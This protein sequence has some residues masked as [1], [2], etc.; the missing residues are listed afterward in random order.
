MF[1]PGKGGGTLDSMTNLPPFDRWGSADGPT[2]TVGLAPSWQGY[3]PHP[4][5]LGGGY[6]D[7][8]GLG[9]PALRRLLAALGAA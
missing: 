8:L 4:D 9:A 1:P 7:E 2:L 5:H 3:L 6:E